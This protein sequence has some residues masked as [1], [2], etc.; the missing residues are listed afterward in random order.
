MSC[1]AG[2]A[3]SGSQIANG[4]LDSPLAIEQ[5][6]GV[7]VCPGVCDKLEVQNTLLV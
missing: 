6:A 5:R 7:Q 2:L 1:E 3:L 4:Y